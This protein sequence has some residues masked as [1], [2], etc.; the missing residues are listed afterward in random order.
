MTFLHT[1]Y[2]RYDVV[3]PFLVECLIGGLDG[4]ERPLEGLL[5]EEI[6]G[7]EGGSERLSLS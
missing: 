6:E 3:F 1:K 2:E 4:T 5:K 7:K